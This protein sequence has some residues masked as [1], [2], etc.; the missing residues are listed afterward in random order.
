VHSG[1]RWVGSLECE[2]TREEVRNLIDRRWSDHRWRWQGMGIRWCKQKASGTQVVILSISKHFEKPL[3]QTF[4]FSC[5]N[6]TVLYL[7]MQKPIY[8][9]VITFFFK[10]VW[11]NLRLTKYFVFAKQTFESAF[12]SINLT[13]GYFPFPKITILNCGT[14]AWV[15]NFNPLNLSKF[16]IKPLPTSPSKLKRIARWRIRKL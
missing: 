10:I 16:T 1:S 15:Y 11:S 12:P 2:A 8:S 5:L 9:L 4:S 3:S 13:N 14:L 7:D 6:Q